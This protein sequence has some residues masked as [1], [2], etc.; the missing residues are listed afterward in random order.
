[1]NHICTNVL[2]SRDNTE[3][4]YIENI[5]I[6]L[7][8]GC[9]NMCAGMYL[10]IWPPTISVTFP[11][12]RKHGFSDHPAANWITICFIQCI[13]SVLPKGLNLRKILYEIQLSIY[14][15]CNANH[16]SSGFYLKT[17]TDQCVAHMGT[18][19]LIETSCRPNDL[20]NVFDQPT[21]PSHCDHCSLN[22]Y[23]QLSSSLKARWQI[24]NACEYLYM[25][26]IVQKLK[27]IS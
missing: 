26:Q 18:L 4:Q 13:L 1:M 15:W 2:N 12:E 11:P 21:Y 9:L 24:G 16:Y 8:V 14:P 23:C 27:L 19:R 5:D 17:D 20:S 6:M 10:P 25:N 3:Q 22:G 7:L